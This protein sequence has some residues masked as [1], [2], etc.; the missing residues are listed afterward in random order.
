[1]YAPPR[2]AGTDA[3]GWPGGI[4]D[5]LDAELVA[6]ELG[7]APVGRISGLGR[8]DSC[9][10]EIISCSADLI[11]DW[12]VNGREPA[13]GALSELYEAA[14]AAARYGLGVADAFRA[15][16][17]AVRAV[18][19]TLRE[20]SLPVTE[21]SLTPQV[22]TLWAFLD[23]ALQTITTAFAD[24]QDLPSADGNSRARTLFARV[25][26][27]SPATIEDIDRAERMGFPL[28]VQHSPF[29]AAID[30][31]SAAAHANLAA[32]MRAA[33]ALAYA[34][35]H[36]VAGLTHPGFEW[37]A[38][39]ADAALILAA[40]P[41]TSQA[42]LADAVSNLHDLV[43]L[44]AR[45][46]RR[47]R[48]RPDDFLTEIMLVN[49]PQLA[50]RIMQ[51]VLGRL[52]AE[53]PSGTLSR[54]LRCLAAHGFDRAATAAALPAHRNTLHY[55]VS[56]IEKLTSLDLSRHAHRE[57]ARLAVIWMETT[58]P[59]AKTDEIGSRDERP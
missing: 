29:V 11:G 32:R 55:R 1:M 30:A 38:F 44:A 58:S 13:A 51:R 26:A 33:G 34:D 10:E 4:L 47:G 7:D 14:R 36:R 41:P 52:N 31:G 53:D 56:R 20:S 39:L 3:A 16:C 42:E 40:Q 48:I 12:L 5:D 6:R 15:C 45:A 46:G 9:R 25:C 35:G 19:G 54:T 24:Q 18:W 22:D 8:L 17:G 57:M 27:R 50:E 2:A 21:N 37:P 28:A 43:T 49:S 23:I 59:Q